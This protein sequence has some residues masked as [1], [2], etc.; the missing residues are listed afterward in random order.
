[1]SNAITQAFA[2]QDRAM[3][4]GNLA[5]IARDF[6]VPAPIFV[7]DRVLRAETVAEVLTFL[8]VYF[9]LV[10]DE[11]S[12]SISRKIVSMAPLP[13]SARLCVVECKYHDE[14]GRILGSSMM[15]QWCR[16][17]DNGMRIELTEFLSLPLGLQPEDLEVMYSELRQGL[18]SP[19]AAS[20][21]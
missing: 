18:A 16:A 20:E 1:M 10:A 13:N 15:R 11:D 5:A 7:R 6:L 2:A 14:N 12:E 3:A 8:K 17:F 19:L 9:K 4:V 21:A